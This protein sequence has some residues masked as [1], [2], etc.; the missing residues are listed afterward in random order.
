MNTRIIAEVGSTH[1]GS[2]ELIK[3]AIDHCV[4]LRIDAIKFQLFSKNSEAAKANVWLDPVIYHE[5]SEYAKEAALQC[6]ASVF[7]EYSLDFLLST[8]PSF[9]KFAYSQKGQRPWIQRV[10]DCG[11]ETI[12]SCDVMSDK[13]V[14]IGCTRLFCIPQ[15]PVYFQICFDELFP[16]FDGYSDHS[17]GFEQTVNAVSAGARVIEKHIRIT[18]SYNCPDDN[19]ALSL[20]EFSTMVA[21]LRSIRQ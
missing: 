12:V 11:I 5:A 19:F 8:D 1:Q 17:M 15:Y 14:P 21:A 6:G 18:S 3:R 7:D 16:R 13:K 9:V 4:L 20:A 2:I 10:L